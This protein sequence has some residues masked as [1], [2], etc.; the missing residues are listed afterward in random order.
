[1]SIVTCTARGLE[2][3]PLAN[4]TKRAGEARTYVPPNFLMTDVKKVGF[5]GRDVD[6]PLEYLWSGAIGKRKLW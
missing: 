6:E 1:M 2:V 5:L 3:L 4:L